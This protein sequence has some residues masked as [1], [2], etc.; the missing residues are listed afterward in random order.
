MES[1]HLFEEQI[2]H[3]TNIIRISGNGMSIFDGGVVD[4]STVRTHPPSFILLKHYNH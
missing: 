4:G 2:W 1:Y 3:M